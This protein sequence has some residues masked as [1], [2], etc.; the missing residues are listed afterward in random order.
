MT[1][2]TFNAYSVAI[3]AT[4]KAI[5]DR[6]KKITNIE[7]LTKQAIDTNYLAKLLFDIGYQEGCVE[8]HKGQK[9]KDAQKKLDELKRQQRR[10]ENAHSLANL[11]KQLKY[12]DEIDAL[13]KALTQLKMLE[14]RKSAVS[15]FLGINE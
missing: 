5:Q 1:S 11:N 4:E 9:R 2:P 10:V 15:Y 6:Q 12:E 13:R 14:S 7:T 3:A 8:H